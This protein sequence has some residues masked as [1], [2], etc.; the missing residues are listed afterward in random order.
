MRE[1]WIAKELNPYQLY[2][3]VCALKISFISW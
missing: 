2:P 1:Y 3:S